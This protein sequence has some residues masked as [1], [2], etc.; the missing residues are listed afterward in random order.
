MLKAEADHLSLDIMKPAQ[1]A[2][3]QIEMATYQM[4]EEEHVQLWDSSLDEDCSKKDSGPDNVSVSPTHEHIGTPFIFI[5]QDTSDKDKYTATVVIQQV[6]K[7]SCEERPR[8]KIYRGEMKFDQY[9]PLKLKC[10]KLFEVDDQINHV[11]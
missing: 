8:R 3:T 4:T 10:P 5:M 1:V 6:Y 2:S 9:L 11:L 7:G